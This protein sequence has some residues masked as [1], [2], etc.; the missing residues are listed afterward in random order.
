MFSR[1]ALLTIRLSWWSPFEARSVF[2]KSHCMLSSALV[3]PHRPAFSLA[4]LAG[5][6]AFGQALCADAS[7]DEVLKQ[8]EQV[9]SFSGVTISPDGNRVAWAQPVRNDAQNSELYLLSWKA[10]NAQ[11]RISAGNGHTAFRE[12]GL[13]WS[14]DS[15]EIAFLSNAAGDGDEVWIWNIAQRKARRLTT[16][17][18][19]IADL[20]WS[21]D[22]RQ[23]A[24]LYAENG[25]GGG[26]L[27]AVPA[28]TGAI[29]TEIHNQRLTLVPTA[30]G[31]IRQ[32]S[33]ENLNVYEYDWAPDG[34][35]VAATAAP[36]PADNNWWVAQLYLLDLESGQMH[37]L[38]KP[39]VERQLAVPRWSPDGKQIAFLG[40]LMSDEGFNGGEIFLVSSGGDTPRNITPGRT[41]S[42]NGFSWNGTDKI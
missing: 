37:V 25:G 39:P 12:S 32:V 38:Y 7:I 24:F 13:S 23:L 31:P 3:F 30:G 20:R 42:P 6:F 40:G 10:G 19:Y 22:A 2:T 41:S 18:G 33:P 8:L 5:L 1:R 9:Q 4:I 16:L 15:S 17:K 21:P 14:P 11:Q 29:G 28:Q 27:E 26:P 35:H 34:K 36:G